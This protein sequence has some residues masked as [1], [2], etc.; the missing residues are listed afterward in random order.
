MISKIFLIKKDT[1]EKRKKT[2]I[3]HKLKVVLSCYTVYNFLLKD[4][5]KTF[6]FNKSN[7]INGVRIDDSKVF[8]GHYEIRDLKNDFI[9]LKLY[10]T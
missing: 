7:R 5:E 2:T 4:D 8:N 10:V 3:Q 9:N 1:F 6:S